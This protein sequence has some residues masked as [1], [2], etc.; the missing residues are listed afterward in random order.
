[1]GMRIGWIALNEASVARE[2]TPFCRGMVCIERGL[3]V[4]CL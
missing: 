1:M 2:C 3:G 4:M